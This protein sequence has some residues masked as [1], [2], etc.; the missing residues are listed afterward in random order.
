MPAR[1][2]ELMRG[3][4]CVVL[5]GCA[6]KAAPVTPDHPRVVVL[7]AAEHAPAAGELELIETADL[8]FVLRRDQ[9]GRLG[10]LSV[11]CPHS[12]CN[13]RVAARNR[14]LVCPCHG[15]RFDTNGDPIEG[16]ASSPLTAL[17]LREEGDSIMVEVGGSP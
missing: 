8:R 4:G 14:E 12:G 17:P 10:A 11:S 7:S 15:S 1:R 3:A 16:P 6:S 5:C 9:D 13:V 2:R